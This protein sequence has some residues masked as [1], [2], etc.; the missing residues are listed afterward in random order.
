MKM[1]TISN[2]G[3]LDL[4]LNA[5]LNLL[6][7]DKIK[8]AELAFRAISGLVEREILKGWLKDLDMQ[9]VDKLVDIEEKQKLGL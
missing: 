7:G 4:F 9:E 1:G 3:A 8:A 2:D 5:S 6:T